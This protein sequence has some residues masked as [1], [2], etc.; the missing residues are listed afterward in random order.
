MSDPLPEPVSRANAEHYTWGDGCDGYYLLKS[1][2][3]QVIE[4]CMPPGTAERM[5]RH[6][7][8]RQL[9]YVLQG[10]LT[11]RFA[12]RDARISAGSALAIEPGLAHQ[13]RNDST[14]EVRFMVVSVPPSHG[15]REDV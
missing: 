1:S 15:D 12:G 9:F 11:M 5:H 2:E 6:G 14:S 10:E 7:R 4:E 13:A 3:A 8:A